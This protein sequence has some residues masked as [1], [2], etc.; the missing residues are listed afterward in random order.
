MTIRVENGVEL[1]RDQP[2][3][4]GRGCGHYMTTEPRALVTMELN[5]SHRY[6][7]T[8]TSF[9]LQKL[10]PRFGDELHG[11]AVASKIFHASDRWYLLQGRYC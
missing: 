5:P 6:Y 3:G 7:L 8:M 2:L 9:P 11:I 10:P 4:T 1:F